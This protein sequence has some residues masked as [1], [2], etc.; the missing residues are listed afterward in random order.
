[1]SKLAATGI[2]LAVLAA[3]AMPGVRPASAQDAPSGNSASPSEAPAEAELLARGKKLVANQHK[4]DD[5][6]D[7]YERVEHEIDST[8][9]A[10]PRTL[11]DKKTRI[12]PN[13]AGTT[14]LLLEEGGRQVTQDEYRRELQ[15]WASVLQFM[16]NPGDP[17]MKSALAKY[18]KKSQTRIELV[19]AMLTAFKRKWV[20]R[21][22]RNGYLCDVIELTPDPSFHPHSI[23]EDA[24]THASA[25]IWVDHDQDQL[26]RAEALITSD[27][28][29]GGG[30]LGKLN[31]GGT[32]V[33]EQ[34]E[35]SPGVWLPSLYKFDY[36]GREFLFSLEKHQSTE[37]TAYRYIG[38]AKDALAVAEGQLASAKPLAGDP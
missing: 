28:W 17:R 21:Q 8:G 25:K 37:I 6:V 35:V 32:F 20:G 29:F 34:T 14:K 1:M 4:N 23:G 12:E 31:K 33:M 36:S 2:L 22:I 15:T 3:S 7:Q 24:L 11:I 19:D 26:V 5:T 38:T 10:R 9:G 27:I 16:V 13:G 30:V 18:Q